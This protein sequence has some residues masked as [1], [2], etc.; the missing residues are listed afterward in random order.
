MK[1]NP[2]IDLFW[3]IH[4]KLYRWSGGRI[5]SSIMGLPVLLLT[6]KGRKTGLLRTKALMYIPYGNN[7]VVYASN[8]GE[9]EHPHWWLNL[10]ANQQANVEVKGTSYN[11]RAREAEGEEREQ[12]WRK[13][14]DRVPAYNQY[15]AR[16][17]RRIPVVVL[18]PQ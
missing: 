11:V 16:T 8:L 17:S 12:L 6:T 5:G 3:R 1:R 13:V 18:E 4:P 2:L 14:T 9:P 10:E 15:Q 7:F